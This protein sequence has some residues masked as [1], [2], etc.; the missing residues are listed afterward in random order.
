VFLDRLAHLNLSK[1]Q[2]RSIEFFAEKHDNN[3]QTGFA[4]L[5]ELHL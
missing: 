2:A 3:K 1:K 5:Q 4:K